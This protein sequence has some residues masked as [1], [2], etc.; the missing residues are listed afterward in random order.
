[1][2]KK[3]ILFRCAIIIIFII[4]ILQ[5]VRIYNINLQINK[6]KNEIKDNNQEEYLLLYNDLKKEIF[7]TESE[8]QLLTSENILDK[9][10]LLNRTKRENEEALAL[11]EQDLENIKSQNNTL[12]KAIMQKEN[13]KKEEELKNK[14]SIYPTY[15]QFPNYP[16]GC[17]SVSLYL[18]LRYY[19]VNVT[20]EDIVN[21]LKKGSLPYKNNNRLIGG[22]P[23]YEFIGNPKTSYSYGVYNKPIAEI[24]AKYKK[25]IVSKV[26]FNFEEVLKL[27]DA[28]HPVLVWT[29]INLSKPFI[30]STWYT[31]SGKKINWISG[32]HAMVIFKTENNKIIASDPYTGTIRYFDKDLFK[33]RYDYLGKRAI[34]YE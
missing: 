1:M 28:N 20:I 18:L 16:T 34:Y 5:L 29:T 10:G 19:G 17:E 12:E 30:S 7:D 4:N 8:T 21:N 23:E 33:T 26:N 27:V 2:K 9:I 3:K 13:A 22:D 15:H 24:G 11:S 31:N 32:E 14:L 25:G 6:L